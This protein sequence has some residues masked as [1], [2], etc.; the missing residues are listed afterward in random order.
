MKP[1]PKSVRPGAH[2]FHMSKLKQLSLKVANSLL[3][4]RGLKPLGQLGPLHSPGLAGLEGGPPLGLAQDRE[5]PQDWEG[6]S[7]EVPQSDQAGEA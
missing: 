4:R 2:R 6:G 7:Q 5:A 1:T 3:K